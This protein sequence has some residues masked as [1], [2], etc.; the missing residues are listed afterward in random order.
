MKGSDIIQLFIAATGGQSWGNEEGT[1]DFAELSSLSPN[2]RY[3]NIL[4]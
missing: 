1:L 4:N 3:R 2:V